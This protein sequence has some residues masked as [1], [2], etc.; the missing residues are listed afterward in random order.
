MTNGTELLK[1]EWSYA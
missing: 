1:F